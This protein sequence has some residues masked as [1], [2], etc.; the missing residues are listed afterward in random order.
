MKIKIT[1]KI[2]NKANEA[3]KTKTTPRIDSLNEE[4]AYLK[5]IKASYG[6]PPKFIK[7]NKDF[8]IKSGII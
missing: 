4:I 1:I 5:R 8:L 2:C 6:F 7:E 3:P